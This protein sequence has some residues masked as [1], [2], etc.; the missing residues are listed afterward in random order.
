MIH[1][2]NKTIFLFLLGILI[3]AGIAGGALQVIEEQ[4]KNPI[5]KEEVVDFETCV[6]EG[7]A[8][9]ESYPRVCTTEKGTRA[10]EDIGNEIEKINLIRISTPRPN[11]LVETPLVIKGEAR[12]Y[13]FFEATFP[14]ELL[15]EEGNMIAQGYASATG[16]PE[17]FG[18]AGW[19]TEEFVPFISEL[20]FTK[21]PH[22]KKGTLILKK[23]NPSGLP[24][25]DDELVVPV[26]FK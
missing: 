11:A 5:H 17:T 14:L 25:H 13:W 6:R 1:I 7:G 12:G 10:V 22:T 26:E 23:D 3:F 21:T 4:K 19:M 15:D 24:E 20:T 18:G 9:A 16:D 8:V 2:G